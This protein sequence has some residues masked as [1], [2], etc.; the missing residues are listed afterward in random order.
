MSEH[1]EC[2][3]G[4]PVRKTYQRLIAKVFKVLS[5]FKSEK[6]NQASDQSVNFC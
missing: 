3:S 6:S 1:A 2:M 4:K 5:T